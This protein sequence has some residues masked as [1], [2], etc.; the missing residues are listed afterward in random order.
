VIEQTYEETPLAGI[1]VVDLSGPIGAYCTRLL[2]DL[3]AD[4]VL[5]EPPDGDPLRRVPPFRDES[6]TESLVFAYYHASKRSVMVNPDDY[7]VLARLGNHADVVVVTPSPESRLYGWDAETRTV[8]WAPGAIVCAIT[9]FGLT[10]PHAWWRS[11]PFVSFAMG[12]NMIRIG[13]AEGPPRMIPGRQV[14][15]EAGVHA[16]I[17]ILAALAVVDTVGPQSIDLSV[18]EVVAGKDFFIEQYDAAGMNMLGRQASVGYPPT[19]TYE[20]LDGSFD[21]AAHQLRHWN[22]FC[23]M[24]GYP[25]ELAD[26]ALADPLVR[27]ERFEELKRTIQGLVHDRSRQDLVLRGQEAGLPCGL[28]NRPTEFVSDGQLAARES[29]VVSPTPSGPF[30]MPMPGSGFRS[31]PRMTSVRTSAPKSPGVEPVTWEPR[32]HANPRTN[33]SSEAPLAGVKVLSFGSF[34]A[35][36]TTA[37]LLAQLGADVAK[38]ESRNRPEVLRMPAYAIGNT[39]TEPSGVTNTVMNASLSRSVRNLSID[40]TTTPGREVF[41]HLVARADVVVENLSASTANKWGVSFERLQSINSR[42]ILTSLSGYGRTGPRASHLAYATNISNFVGLTYASG[43]CHGTQSD[44]IAAEH[45]VLGTLAALRHV[46][47]TGEGVWVDSAQIEAMAAVMPDIVLEA[48]VNGR[49][50]VPTG[51]AVAGSLLSGA[52]RC[53]GHDAWVAVEIC[54]LSDWDR[55]CAAVDVPL[56][57]DCL[58]TAVEMRQALDAAL[59]GWAELRTSLGAARDLQR[60]GLAAG[61]VQ[62]VEDIWRDPQLWS[63]RFPVA[64]MQ[65][66]LG[67]YHYPESPYRLAET[68]GHVGHAGHRLGEDTEAVLTEWLGLRTD[69]V[70]RLIDVGAAFQV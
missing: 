49:D 29:L 46:A 64:F 54:D 58:E 10:G 59:Q 35:G 19:G 21:V 8:D 69:D 18:H 25:D 3:G 16:A 26:P 5:V 1:R 30:P 68:P 17:C 53:V 13:S 23:E 24:L 4:V 41:G 34:V 51:N 65:P 70:K 2:A 42:I 45:A 32:P 7:R 56:Q 15:D 33:T 67:T 12:G 14:W 22:A 62:S 37:S 57:A 48:V 31:T 40:V 55:L 52:Y 44:Y 36:N 38:V 66:D 28:L 43:H 63:R 47:A 50:V 6:P 61:V 9:P 20:C 27:R 11:T 60:A 39:V